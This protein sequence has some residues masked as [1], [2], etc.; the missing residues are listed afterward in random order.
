MY[1]KGMNKEQKLTICCREIPQ[2]DLQVSVAT[3]TNSAALHMPEPE[4]IDHAG[5]DFAVFI[6]IYVLGV[7]IFAPITLLA[8]MGLVPIN[9]TGKTLEAPTAKDLTFSNIDKLSISNVPFESNRFWAHIGMSYVFS[10]WTCYSLYK[11]YRIIAS[12]R[13]RFLASEHRRPDQF[14][15]LV[16][17]VPLD[18]DESVSEHIEHFFASIILIT[19]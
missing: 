1:M 16:R 17:N 9:W 6:Q 14:T 4:L 11:E 10:A 19:I 18:M 7:K 13:L 5:L 8:F 3:N 12:M 2:T 15:V